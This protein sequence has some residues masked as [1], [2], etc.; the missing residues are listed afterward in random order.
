MA[1]ID[2]EFSHTGLMTEKQRQIVE[3]AGKL[4]AEQGYE[5]TSMDKV[6]TEANVS[7][8]TVYSYFDSKEHLFSTVMDGMCQGF[9]EPSPDAIGFSGDMRTVLK[10]AAHF[11]LSRVTAPD[12]IRLMR[13]VIGEVE[14]F[15]QI[16]DVFWRSGPGKMRD[17]LA[18]Y[19]RG[20]QEKGLMK[21]VDPVLTA[22][23]FQG[24][25]VGPFLMQTLLSGASDW[26]QEQIMAAI[27]DAVEGFTEL[28]AP[29]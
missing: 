24:I 1:H 14:K 27:D 16:G 6:A 2:Q 19:F 13:T 22:G 23:Q 7:K 18:D 12:K 26:S 17:E 9:F 28:Y 21:K 3:A 20:M 15:P 10:E 29:D 5:V 25:I 8:R 11:L 4:F